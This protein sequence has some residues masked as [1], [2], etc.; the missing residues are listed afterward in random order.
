[1]DENRLKGYFSDHGEVPQSMPHPEGMY[2]EKA[3]TNQWEMAA[4][5]WGSL[6]SWLCSQSGL[7]NKKNSKCG[8]QAS[9][10]GRSLR[11]SLHETLSNGKARKWHGSQSQR[12]SLGHNFIHMG[13]GN[14]FSPWEKITDVSS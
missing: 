6:T 8:W 2:T 12:M 9:G 1:M 13:S 5:P 10:R 3:V 4:S 7:V 14:C 11:Q